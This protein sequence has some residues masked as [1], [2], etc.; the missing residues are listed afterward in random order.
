MRMYVP[1]SLSNTES[2]EPLSMATSSGPW[3]NESM[4]TGER[5]QADPVP[6][7]LAPPA[8]PSPST[9]LTGKSIQTFHCDRCRRTFVCR[10]S[11]L[12]HRKARRC[13]Q[14]QEAPCS[15]DHTHQPIRLQFDSM[16][17]ALNWRLENQLD[18]YFSLKSAKNSN[19]TPGSY[20]IMRCNQNVKDR[21]ASSKKSKKAYDCAAKVIFNQ[22][23]VCVCENHEL[24]ECS[25][26]K[27][28]V[29]VYG[30]I[31]H[32]HPIERN[33]IR[34]SKVAKDRASELIAS[35]VPSDV[36]LKE[37]RSMHEQDPESK[38]LKYEDIYRIKKMCKLKGYGGKNVQDITASHLP[39][40]STLKG[41]LVRKRAT[42]TSI[43][44]END[45]D[46]KRLK[47]EQKE[48]NVILKEFEMVEDKM[49]SIKKF[50]IADDKPIAEKKHLVDS[51]S[52]L[53]SNFVGSSP[54]SD[55]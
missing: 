54:L 40:G 15:A 1:S 21:I 24:V 38:P 55:Q 17:E 4:M 11:V 48:L 22:K 13:R 3:P 53:L 33:K 46:K 20:R 45:I 39:I 12:S 44:S 43:S 7:A 27:Q 2:N 35:G 42:K 49:S 23:E 5:D 25:N 16:T 32:S 6:G 29:L 47:N 36:V 52:S 19:G 51:L 18:R 8:S 28:Q 30:C 50:L 9:L 31:E 26:V 34:L 10:H 37:Y 41:T 14:A